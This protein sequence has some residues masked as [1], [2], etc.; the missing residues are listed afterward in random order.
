MT[1]GGRA[2]PFRVPCRF[3]GKEGHLVMDQLRTVDC[4]SLVKRLGRLCPSALS[5]ALGVLRE[6]VAE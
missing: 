3:G 6:M 5:K 2:Y 4:R 1:A